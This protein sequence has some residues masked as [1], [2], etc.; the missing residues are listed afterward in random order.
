MSADTTILAAIV[1][2]FL[3]TMR[4]V[5]AGRIGANVREAVKLMTAGALAWTVWD[6]FPELMAGGSPAARLTA[7]TLTG[8]GQ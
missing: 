2:P 4:V 7:E 3:D 1:L 8:L 6:P 5:S